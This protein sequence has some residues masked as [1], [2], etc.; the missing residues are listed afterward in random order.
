MS[1]KLGP[2]ESQAAQRAAVEEEVG[3]ILAL[4]DEE[5]VAEAKRDGRDIAAEAAEVKF[6]FDCALHGVSHKPRGTA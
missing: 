3:R 4:S 6:I 2:L 1:N 5:I